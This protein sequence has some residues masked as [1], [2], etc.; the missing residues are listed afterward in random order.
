MQHFNSFDHLKKVV[1]FLALIKGTKHNHLL[2]RTKNRLREYR[3]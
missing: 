3:F 1:F 2:T